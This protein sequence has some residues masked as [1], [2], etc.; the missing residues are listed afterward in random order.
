VLRFT[1]RRFTDRPDE[2]VAEVRDALERR[3]GL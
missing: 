3:S 1:W 2:V